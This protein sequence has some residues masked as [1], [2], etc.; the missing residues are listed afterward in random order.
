MKRVRGLAGT[1]VVLLVAGTLL[2][3]APHAG[4][5][6]VSEPTV[7]GP[8]GPVN[9]IAAGGFEGG[10]DWVST[11]GIDNPRGERRSVGTPR[12]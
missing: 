12:W 7:L 8:S 11:Q 4:A 5:V 3:A 6:L 1:W 10:Y 2:T 9:H